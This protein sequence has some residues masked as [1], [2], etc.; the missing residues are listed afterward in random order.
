[1]YFM[2]T[3]L[4]MASFFVELFVL[5]TLF[6]FK[7]EK[8]PY[9]VL[10]LIAAAVIGAAFYYLPRSILITCVPYIIITAYVFLCGI[11]LYKCSFLN[12]LFYTLAAFATQHIVW[13]VYAI[14]CSFLPKLLTWHYII[15]YLAIYIGL[16]SL[17]YVIFLRR[18]P[19]YDVKRDKNVVIIISAVILLITTLATDIVTYFGGWN[20]LYRA[21][22]MLCC[23]FALLFQFGVFQRGQLADKASALERDNAILEQLLNQ[24]K[25]QQIL[26]AETIEL[27]NMK[28]HDLKHQITA[29]RNMPSEAREHSISDI[30]KAI[31]VYGD[32][33]KTGNHALDIVLTEKGLICEKHKVRFTYMVDGEKLSFMDAV[34]ISSL[35]G[36]A[37]ENAIHSVTTEEEDRRIIRLNVAEKKSFLHIHC[38]NYSGR[39]VEFK[40][41]LPVTDKADTKQHGFGAKSISYIAKKYGGSMMMAQENNL[42]V[43][44]VLMPLPA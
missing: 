13:S 19:I 25:K 10:K 22:S 30:E 14:L 23:I 40:D 15:I 38:E 29:L 21:Y 3:Y 26:T 35:F 39:Q 36:N 43:L 18:F 16:Y 2:A 44:D 34:D 6:L 33:A 11:F 17:I 32:I 41:G 4:G 9:F 24:E 20:A 7:Q 42:F 28:C 12:V 27:I 37:I 1:M 5:Q 8:R 31:M